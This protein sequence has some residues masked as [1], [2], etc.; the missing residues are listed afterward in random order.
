VIPV[1]PTIAAGRSSVS[2][3]SDH[4]DVLVLNP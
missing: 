3:A 1:R 4:L 2:I